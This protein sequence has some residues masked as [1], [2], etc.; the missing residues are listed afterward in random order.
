MENYDAAGD[1]VGRNI[2][3]TPDGYGLQT[4]VSGGNVEIETAAVSGTGVRGKVQIKAKELDMTA[5]KIRNLANATDSTDALNK[6]QLDSAVSTLS[7]EISGKQASLGTGTTSEYLR[8]DLTWQAVPAALVAKKET[9]ILS[10][11][12]LSNGYIDCAH[13][14][15]ADSMLLV[16][17]GIPHQEGVSEDYVLSNVGGVTRIT[18]NAGLL[19]KLSVGDRVYVMYQK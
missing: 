1:T 8:G 10:S 14:S 3:I 5:T 17:G 4:N 9:F 19:A 12:D 7:I 16:T 15:A 13:L 18:F 2:F 11:T 6:G